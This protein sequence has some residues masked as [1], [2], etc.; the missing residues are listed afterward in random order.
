V[1]SDVVLEMLQ[2]HE[3]AH[4]I[5]RLGRSVLEGQ[6]EH[7]AT[8][9]NPVDRALVGFTIGLEPD[10]FVPRADERSERSKAT[11]DLQDS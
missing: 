5:E 6:V 10:V 7:L 1:G 11:A 3:R 9:A 8:R 4:E 2:D